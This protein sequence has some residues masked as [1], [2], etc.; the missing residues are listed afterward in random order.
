MTLES[1]RILRMLTDAWLLDFKFGPG[2]CAITLA[3]LRALRLG[4]PRWIH[5]S[6][7]RSTFRRIHVSGAAARWR[8]CGGA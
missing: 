7:P 4:H 5:I 1:M 2:R 8:R 6:M 3:W